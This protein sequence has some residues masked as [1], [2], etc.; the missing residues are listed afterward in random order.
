MSQH[1]PS[2]SGHAASHGASHGHGH[3][4]PEEVRKEVRKYLIVFGA[5]LVGTVLTVWASYINFGSHAMNVFVG[6]V[7]ASVKAFLVAGFFMHLIDERKMVYA[8]LSATVFFFIGL[9][10]LTLWSLHPSS[11][12]HIP[13]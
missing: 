7:I 11:L 3:H 4:T 6:M 9:M 12:I 2:A 10:Y 13:K 5:L 1:S 8:V